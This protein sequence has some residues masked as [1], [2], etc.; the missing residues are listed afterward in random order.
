MSIN[1]KPRKFIFQNAGL[2]IRRSADYRFAI[3][4]FV[5]AALLGNN[6]YEEYVEALGEQMI[7]LQVTVNGR[8]LFVYSSIAY[9]PDEGFV[10]YY[11]PEAKPHFENALQTLEQDPIISIASEALGLDAICQLYREAINR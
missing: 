5:F 8:D 7:G 10:A 4:N 9:N 3:P 11:N 6:S 1:D 2:E